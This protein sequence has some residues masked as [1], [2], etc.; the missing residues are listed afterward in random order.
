MKSNRIKNVLRCSS[1]FVCCGFYGDVKGGSYC[2]CPGNI[3]CLGNWIML[4]PNLVLACECSIQPLR[5]YR[6]AQGSQMV[7]NKMLTSCTVGVMLRVLAALLHHLSARE[8]LDSKPF[9]LCH[10]Y[11][12]SKGY[13]KN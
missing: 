2:R 5:E 12:T 11:S 7:Q 3:M 8:S 4:N 9:V 13:K 6:W 1:M 10:K